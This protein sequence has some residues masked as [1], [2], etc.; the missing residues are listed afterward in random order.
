M[1]AIGYKQALPI[2]DTHAL[3]EIELPKPSAQGRDLLVKIEAISVNPVDTKIRRGVQPDEGQ[4]R[5]LGWD[6][7]G[8]VESVGQQVSLFKPGDKVW[9]S[10]AL[11]RPGANAEYQLVDERVTAK[12]PE[13]LNFAEAAALPLT[14]V[15]AWE[16]MFHRLNLP[17][18]S[19]GK[20]LIIG[21][22]GGVGSIMIQLAKRL[23]QLEV[24]A[25]ASRPETKD[26]VRALGADYVID[27]SKPLADELKA[28][29]FDNVDYVTSLTNTDDHLPSIV[30]I[31]A[32]QGKLGVIDDPEKLDIMP[33]KR[34]SISIHW[35]LMFTRT[36]FET[37]DMIEQHKILTSIAKMVD[38]GELKS[39][40]ADNFGAINAANLVK[41]HAL[42]ESGK[43]RG[44]IVL[45]G[46]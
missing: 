39:T 25:T 42:L 29:G 9:Y 34:K 14:S 26:W 37:D 33:F 3:E 13:S 23:T 16:L 28:I 27:H 24:I 11:N 31:I 1:K 7:T 21:A 45:S 32:P 15:T 41:A 46:F 5:V 6:A 10:G 20:L 35:E 38:D 44:K 22:A 18:T 19:S 8:V 2:S 30:D 12:M 40:V 17:T 4:Y 43:A 36:L